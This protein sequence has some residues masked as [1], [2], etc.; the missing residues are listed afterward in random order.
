MEKLTKKE[1]ERK[2]ESFFK[3]LKNKTPKEIKKIKK[4]AM[5]NNI[6]VGEKRKLFCKK[7]NIIFNSKNSKTRIK[8]GR[9]IILCNKCGQ[10]SRWKLKN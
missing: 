2:I 10:I 3:K 4:L 9:K 5:R 7:C 8:R 6:K 1:A